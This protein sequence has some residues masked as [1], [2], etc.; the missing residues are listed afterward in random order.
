MDESLAE[1]SS[2]IYTWMLGHTTSEMTPVYE[3]SIEPFD[4]NPIEMARL[5]QIVEIGEK[6]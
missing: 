3:L 5:Y 4:I 6:Q 2:R 1:N